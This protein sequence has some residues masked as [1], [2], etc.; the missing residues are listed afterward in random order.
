M[1][2]PG[3][4]RP[5]SWKGFTLLELL[6][7]VGLIAAASIVVLA[8]LGERR[9][10]ALHAGQ[11]SLANFITAARTRASAHGRH[12]RLLFHHDAASP[13]AAERYLRF[14]VME[15]LRDG[16][17][18]SVQNVTLPL[19]VF[20][21]PHQARIEEGMLPNPALWSKP[22]GSRLHSS[23]LF[24]PLVQ[25]QVDAPVAELWAE[26]VFSPHGTT[27]SSGQLVLARA[28]P[29]HSGRGASLTFGPPEEVRGAQVSAYGLV[30]SIAAR[31]EF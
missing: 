1:S 31:E 6:V 16:Q 27:A 30:T 22:D 26:I 3:H 19:G 7:V 11:A 4:R 8:G 18:R 9:G 25:R 15:E 10:T 14:V 17:W 20:F 5:C 28:Q 21:L 13:Q 23:A 24:R 2:A 29:T 12:V